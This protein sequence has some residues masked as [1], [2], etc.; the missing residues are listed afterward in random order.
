M[1]TTFT[2]SND[3][4]GFSLMGTTVRP[5]AAE[6]EFDLIESTVV[7]AG[8]SPPHTLDYDKVFYVLDGEIV[9]I[10]DG[11]ERTARRGDAATV[12]AGVVHNYVN[13]SGS[14]A[15]MLVL[16]GGNQHVPFLRGLASLTATGAP[17]PAEMADHAARHG[18]NLLAHA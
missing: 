3:R 16:T 6:H 4:P 10:M 11:T 18:V 14:E 9:L 1:D 8:G 5:V 17:D 15:R 7:P 2:T 13:R 12:P